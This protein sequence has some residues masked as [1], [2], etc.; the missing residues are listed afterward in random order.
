MFNN[1][2]IHFSFQNKSLKKLDLSCNS[3]SNFDVQIENLEYLRLNNNKIREF[4]IANFPNIKALYLHENL[5][6]NIKL[7]DSKFLKLFYVF[8]CK[9]LEKNVLDIEKNYLNKIELRTR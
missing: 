3:L 5:L 8:N 9:L 7:T 2:L 4:N 6:E 1:K